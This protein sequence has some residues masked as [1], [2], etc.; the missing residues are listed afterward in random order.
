M[1]VVILGCA[2][3]G[4]TTFARRLGTVTGARVISLDEI[5]QPEWS[6]RDVPAFRESVRNA[7]GSD[8]WISDG[9]FALATFDIRLSNATL[10]IWLERSRFFCLRRAVAR[11]FGPNEPHRIGR[12]F[13]VLAFIWNFDRINRPR[14]EKARMMH[15][16]SVPILRLANEEE[17]EGFISSPGK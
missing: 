15:G 11:V 7:H 6:E 1:R 17:I 10:V 4:K 12:L 13:K 9:N 16:A 5:W 3:S 14:I 8:S 2:G